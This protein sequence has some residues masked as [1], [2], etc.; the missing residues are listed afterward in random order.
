MV[1][2]VKNVFVFPTTII[3]AMGC[4]CVHLEANY[5]EHL[6]V[7]NWS[8]NKFILEITEFNYTKK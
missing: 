6:T 3:Q 4:D 2:C 8:T 1:V 5:I 7:R